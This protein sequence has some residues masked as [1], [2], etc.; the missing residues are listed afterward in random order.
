MTKGGIYLA[1]WNTDAFLGQ[2]NYKR[3]VSSDKKLPKA[4]TGAQAG[5]KLSFKVSRP[6]EV[7]VGN[8]WVVPDYPHLLVSKLL[9][10][11][12]PLRIC[13]T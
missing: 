3:E 8:L 5:K 7:V 11:P 4:H 13:W 6:K 9:C 1:T 12:L 2:D 10:H